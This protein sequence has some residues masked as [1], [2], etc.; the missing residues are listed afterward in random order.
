[1]IFILKK[2]W[3]SNIL[4]RL[5]STIINLFNPRFGVWDRDNPIKSKSKQNRE[6]DS[7]QLNIEGKKLKNFKKNIQ[8]K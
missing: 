5:R 1:M 4:D 7:N 8:K 6:P 2:Y 3:D